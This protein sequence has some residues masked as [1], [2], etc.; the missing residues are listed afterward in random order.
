MSNEKPQNPRRKF[1]EICVAG[2]AGSAG[3]LA[4][5]AHAA[6]NKGAPAKPAAKSTEPLAARSY[7]RVKLVD[8]DGKAIKARSLKPHHNYVFNYPYE[9][10]PCF[11]LNLD[12]ALTGKVALA[13]EAGSSTK[14]R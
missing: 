9:S 14:S 10:T 6:D 2:A 8:Q 3:C 1:I 5:A 13:T 12:Q 11:L 7:S 4:A